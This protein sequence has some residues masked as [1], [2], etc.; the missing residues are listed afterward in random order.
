MTP[1]YPPNTGHTIN[2]WGL[3]KDEFVDNNNWPYELYVRE[4]RRMVGDFV[5]TQKDVISEMQKPDPIGLGSY[6][7]DVHRVQGYAN[8]KGILKYE[9]GL[10]RTEQER[11]KHIPYQIPYRAILPNDLNVPTSLLQC[12][13]LLVT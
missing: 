10:Q 6:G 12:V 7:L 2:Q 5:M 4:A 8:E 3:S 11:M 1:V 13:C 9:G